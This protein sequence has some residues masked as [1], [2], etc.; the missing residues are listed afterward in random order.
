MHLDVAQHGW[1]SSEA[2]PSVSFLWN[3]RNAHGCIQL[4]SW[5]SHKA[6]LHVLPLWNC[7]APQ[8]FWPLLDYYGGLSRWGCC[9]ACRR[10]SASPIRNAVLHKIS[11][12][13]LLLHGPCSI[14]FHELSCAAIRG[15]LIFKHQCRGPRR[16]LIKNGKGLHQAFECLTCSSGSPTKTYKSLMP[17]SIFLPFSLQWHGV[18]QRTFTPLFWFPVRNFRNPNLKVGHFFDSD[19]GF[20]LFL[21]PGHVEYCDFCRHDAFQLYASIGQFWA[22]VCVCVSALEFLRQ[23]VGT[24]FRHYRGKGPETTWK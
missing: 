15:Q 5:W 13:L 7:A 12:E 22:K 8:T 24:P 1:W 16:Y 2:I 14:S 9:F 4:R 3:L 6:F 11:S 18:K 20:S 10:H 23:A 21:P 17:T 19:K